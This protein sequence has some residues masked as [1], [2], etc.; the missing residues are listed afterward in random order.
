[1]QIMIVSHIVAGPSDGSD[2]SPS[3][4]TGLVDLEEET[5]LHSGEACKSN[6][7]ALRWLVCT[8]TQNE[9]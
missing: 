4:W 5:S 7:M 3:N 9:V 1:M 8:D 6:Y 2:V